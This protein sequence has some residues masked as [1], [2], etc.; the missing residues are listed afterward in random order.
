MQSNFKVRNYDTNKLESFFVNNLNWEKDYNFI[1]N[2]NT[3]LLGN[4]KNINY[5]T[6]NVSL[7]KNDTTNELF[8][9][10]GFLS[11]IN[12]TKTNNDKEHFLDPKFFLRLS[13]GSMR[14]Q[15]NG[16]RLT[17]LTAFNM[18]R[19]DDNKNFETGIS[20]TFGFDYK[21]REKN[22][23]KFNLSLAQVINEKENNKM[24]DKTSLNEKLSDIVGSSNYKINDN[25]NL[26]Y[27]FSIDQNYKDINYSE[28]ATSYNFNS[29]NFDF[30]YLNEKKHIGDKNYFTTEINYKNTNN[31]MLSFETK[32]DLITNSSEF[33]NLSYE[34]FNDCLKAGLVYRREFYNDSELEPENSLMFKITLIPFGSIDSPT[35]S[36]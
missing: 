11:E 36:N 8:G 31:A 15:L 19:I 30:G 14:N 24:A 10:L 21:I 7:Y 26:K 13:P 29:I 22:K 25:L 28:I 18:D 3:K 12:L 32:R 4:I 2:I 6:K 17:P 34:Y 33:Y 16:S 20:G 27:N 23:T 5:E 9:A 1:P 35:F